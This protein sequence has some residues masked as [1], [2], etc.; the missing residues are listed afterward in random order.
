LPGV[1]TICLM[2]TRE[3]T[4]SSP[5]IKR[6]TLGRLIRQSLASDARH[7]SVLTCYDAST[8]RWLTRAGIDMLLVGDTAAEMTLGH[9]RTIDM[10]LDVLL[11]LTAGVKRGIESAVA[12]SNHTLAGS[13]VMGDMPF[14][15]YHHDQNQAIVNAGRFLTEGLADVVKL[16]VDASFAP[17]IAG[18]TRAGVP[19]CAHIGSRPQ[20]VAMSG[21][22][23]SAG[24]SS[25]QARQILLDAQASIDAG[26]VM[27][28]V[29]AVPESLAQA[30]IELGR[31]AGVPVIGIGAGPKC[32]GQVVVLHDVLGL[33]DRAP[34]FAPVLANIGQ[35]IQRGAEAW[36]DM[37]VSGR[38]P[39][40]PYVSELSSS[41]RKSKRK[42]VGKR[43]R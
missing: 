2:S 9:A 10:N 12:A 23:S 32:H 13:L 30:V 1:P 31:R 43:G 36:H 35:A 27:L 20:R 18:I 34:A 39:A 6:A 33:S 15:S 8:A 16:E 38:V 25:E 40:S 22:Y 3:K 5:A 28:L 4:T 24:K 29:E 41:Q 14:M 21:G 42:N 37:V 11:A 19:V 17:V 26:A 7:F